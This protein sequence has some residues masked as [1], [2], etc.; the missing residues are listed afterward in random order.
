M[1]TSFQYQRADGGLNG[2][3]NI[4]C[5]EFNASIPYTIDEKSTDFVQFGSDVRLLAKH[6][7]NCDNVGLI[8]NMKLEQD[9]AQQKFRYRYGC[10]VLSNLQ[11]QTQSI[12]YNDVTTWNENNNGD[13]IYLDRHIV[14]CSKSGYSINEVEL[15]IKPDNDRQWRYEFKC[16]KFLFW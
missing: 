8:R 14:R 7:L 11:Y 9:S 1:L 16:C 15:K 6:K 10:Y 3:Y 4:K 5:C 13:V 2:R 12:C